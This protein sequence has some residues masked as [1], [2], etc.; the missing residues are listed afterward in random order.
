[1][2]TVDTEFRD[3]RIRIMF[4]ALGGQIQDDRVLINTALADVLVGHR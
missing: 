2:L 1:L 4:R 3:L